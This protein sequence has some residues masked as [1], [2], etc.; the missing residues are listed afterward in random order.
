[1][2]QPDEVRPGRASNV[3]FLLEADQEEAQ[4]QRRELRKLLEV[5]DRKKVQFR[6][7]PSRVGIKFKNKSEEERYLKL[8]TKILLMEHMSRPQVERTL[9]TVKR[10]L[11]EYVALI[12]YN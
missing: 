7:T 11:K 12:K 10:F 6:P 9:L 8:V 1:M 2:S 3:A 5:K 4:P